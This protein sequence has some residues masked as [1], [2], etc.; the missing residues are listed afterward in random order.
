MRELCFILVFL[1]TAL[2]LSNA[3]YAFSI[4][5][6][7]DYFVSIFQSASTALTGGFGSANSCSCA[8]AERCT[9]GAERECVEVCA[10]SSGC[11]NVGVWCGSAADCKPQL[12][13]S[14]STARTTTTTLKTTSTTTTAP[15][16]CHCGDCRETCRETREGEVCYTNCYCSAGCANA[17]IDCTYDSKVCK[18]GTTTSTTTAPKTTS[19]TT[20]TTIPSTCSCGGCKEICT[21]SRDEDICS[22]KCYCSGGC[23]NAGADCTYDSKICKSGTTVSTTTTMKTT[24]TTTTTTTIPST[25]Y[26]GDCRETCRPSRDEDICSINCYCSGGCANTGTVCTS[27]ANCRVIPTTTTTVPPFSIDPVVVYSNLKG[28][29][30]DNVEVILLQRLRDFGIFNIKSYPVKSF[31]QLNINETKTIILLH[32]S[33]RELTPVQVEKIKTWVREGGSLIGIGLSLNNTGM[34]DLF[35]VYGQPQITIADPGKS[36]ASYLKTSQAGKIFNGIKG[37]DFNP[38]YGL[39]LKYANISGRILADIYNSSKSSVIGT[40]I[41]ENVYGFGKTYYFG[42]TVGYTV[43]RMT[44]G[45]GIASASFWAPHQA[46]LSYEYWNYPVADF[47]LY[48]IINLILERQPLFTYWVPNGKTSLIAITGDTDSTNDVQIDGWFGAI[49]NYNLVGTAFLLD[50]YQHSFSSYRSNSGM[51][52]GTHKNTGETYATAKQRITNG[53][54]P[55]PISNRNHFL[56]WYGLANYPREMESCGILFDSSLAAG[57]TSPPYNTSNST[58]VYGYG[59]AL[60]YSFFDLNGNMISTLEIPMYYYDSYYAVRYNSNVQ[61]LNDSFDEVYSKIK[62]FKS[63]GTLLL[64]QNY[65]YNIHPGFIHFFRH[66]LEKLSRDSGTIVWTMGNI[67]NWWLSRNSMYLTEKQ[68]NYFA[69]DAGATVNGLS[70][71]TN[72]TKIRF[73][74]VETGCRAFMAV[75]GREWCV[76]TLNITKGAHTLALE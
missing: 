35:G 43:L 63:V 14:T 61:K 48:P 66:V 2:L 64:H 36:Q 70:F 32:P 57:A 34:E 41:V 50:D 68:R 42:Y 67:G 12:T 37:V 10:C 52:F 13:T 21:P 3:A 1:A 60:P 65:L 56:Q 23:S 22:T 33:E 76:Y 26:C 19:T 49:K 58:G 4:Q 40:G 69:I 47:H 74:G 17:G 8:C 18:G 27:S 30:Y 24:S 46:V 9:G 45:K 55:A 31:E 62:D 73:D 54:F 29:E 7:L 25:C 39:V 72:S 20:T 15:A 5:D 59:S 44:E 38:A 75:L 71:V 11:S 28:S 6:I 16:T 53:G 51:E